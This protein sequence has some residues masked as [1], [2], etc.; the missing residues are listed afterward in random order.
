MKKFIISAATFG[1]LA[2]SPMGLAGTAWAS[3]ADAVIK[4]LQADGYTVAI[5]GS[6]TAPLTA[7]TVTA[8]NK[9]D[10]G[11]TTSASVDIACP[12]GC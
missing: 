4:G 2:G 7:C 5:N 11:A 10:N 8:V 12:Q 3:T 1:V 6:P 9:L